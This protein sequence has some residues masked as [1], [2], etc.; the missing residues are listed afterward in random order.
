VTLPF[1]SRARFADSERRNQELRQDLAAL[2]DTHERVLDEINFRSSGFH[3]YSRFEK[4]AEEPV[5][6][7]AASTDE[8][9][10]V[11][12]GTRVRGQ[13]RAIEGK[14]QAEYEK[15]RRDQQAMDAVRQARAASLMEDAVKAGDQ[16]AQA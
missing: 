5:V 16:Q 6:I 10:I 2:R 7:K 11:N 13:L 4:K 8:Q 15:E 3:L 1:V 12:S 9:P 14:N